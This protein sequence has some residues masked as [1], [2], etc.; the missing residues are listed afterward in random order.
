MFM[1]ARVRNLTLLLSIPLILTNM[2]WAQ[3]A[4]GSV[5][6]EAAFEIPENEKPFWESAQKFVDAYSKRDAAAIGELFTEEATFL[7]ELKVRTSGRTAIVTRFEEAFAE[8]A[9]VLIDSIHIE[10]VRHL[11]D[12]VA[13]EEGTVVSS[14][15]ADSPRHHNR[16]VAIHRKGDDGI[17]RIDILKDFPRE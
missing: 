6:K 17:W 9:G 5:E 3:D 12:S 10:G 8:S 11:G 2:T 13:I 1:A 14:A 16:Y 4:V 15:S 7:D